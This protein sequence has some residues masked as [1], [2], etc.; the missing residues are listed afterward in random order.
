MG[1][2]IPVTYYVIIYV[3]IYSVVV[4][5]FTCSTAPGA[6]PQNFVAQSRATGSIQLSWRPP[7]SDRH[8]GIIIGYFIT[9]Q[10][11][12]GS[13]DPNTLTEPGLS[14]TLSQLQS[15]VTYIVKIAAVNGAGTSLFKAV[16]MIRTIPKRE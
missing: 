1:F 12:G 13:G 5:L 16:V 8:Y 2:C 9:Y 3:H 15:N 7:P 10:I 11:D 4:I 6:A 14:T